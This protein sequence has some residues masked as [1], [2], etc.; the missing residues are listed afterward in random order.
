MDQNQNSQTNAQPVAPPVPPQP[1]QAPVPPQTPQPVQLVAQAQPQPVI[2]QPQ[3]QPTAIVNGQAFQPAPIHAN[4]LTDKKLSKWRFVFI[5]LGVVQLISVGIFFGVWSMIQ[6]QTGGEFVAL[7][8][9][10]TIV[11][12]TGI[13]ALLN[14]IGLPIYIAKHKPQGKWLVLSAISLVISVILALYGAYTAY[15]MFVVV[16]QKA[17]QYQLELDEKAKQYEERY[18][19]DQNGIVNE[20]IQ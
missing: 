15:S 8:M 13:I 9:F 4:Q 11:P 5:F 14:L 19:Q 17:D 7:L 18:R 6:G 16:P 1:I 10:M 12:V 2:P 3:V 20:P